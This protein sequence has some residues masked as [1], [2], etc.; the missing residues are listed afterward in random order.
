MLLEMQRENAKL[1]ELVQQLSKE[2]QKLK[3][4]RTRVPDRPVSEPVFGA[5]TDN[6]PPATKKRAIESQTENKAARARSEI[7]D[8]LIELQKAI[9]SVHVAINEL[10]VRVAG[11]EEWKAGVTPMLS[12]HLHVAPQPYAEAMV[13]GPPQGTPNPVL[14]IYIL[15][16]ANNASKWQRFLSLFKRATDLAGQNPIVIGGDFNAPS[17]TRGYGYDTAKAYTQHPSYKAAFCTT[18]SSPTTV[19]LDATLPPE[20]LRT[21]DRG[22]KHSFQLALRPYQAL[23]MARDVAN[24]V[25]EPIAIVPSVKAL[26]LPYELRVTDRIKS[27]RGRQ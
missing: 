18:P 10:T 20:V 19:V 17:T 22:P 23:A 1:R 26:T 11:I 8:T 6:R 25:G 2:I 5:D 21:L 12:Q 4:D 16:M 15:I 3:Q 27:H 9:A 24:R 14:S 7:K 13:G